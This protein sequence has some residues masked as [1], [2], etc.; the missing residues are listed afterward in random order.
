M[1]NSME[2]SQKK[3]L[4]LVIGLPYDPVKPLLGIYPKECK[5]VYSRENCTPMFTS[6]LF[7]ISKIWKQPVGLQLMKESRNFGTY[8]Q[9]SV[10]QP[11]EIMTWGLKV[12]GCN[13]RTSH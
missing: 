6:T 9:W 4:F 5:T 8:T 3:A 7:T 13:W 12:N 1:E 2:I 10:T 11:Q